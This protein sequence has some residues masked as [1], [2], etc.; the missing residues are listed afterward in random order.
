VPSMCCEGHVVH[1]LGARIIAQPI[2]GFAP[3]LDATRS[4]RGP[5]RH[6]PRATARTLGADRPSATSVA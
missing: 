5:R 2:A 4:D 6:Q 1:D 3:A